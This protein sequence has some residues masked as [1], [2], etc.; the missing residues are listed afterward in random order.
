M[1]CSEFLVEVEGSVDYSKL[2]CTDM[3]IFLWS[4]QALCEKA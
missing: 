3:K 4:E 2:D 1:Y